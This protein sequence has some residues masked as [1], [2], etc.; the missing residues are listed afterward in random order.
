MVRTGTSVVELSD[1]ARSRIIALNQI[2]ATRSVR[3]NTPKPASRGSVSG[4]PTSICCLRPASGLAQK[5]E[6]VFSRQS[7]NLSTGASRACAPSPSR[8][9]GKTWQAT[10]RRNPLCIPA[11]LLRGGAV[12][13]FYCKELFLTA[14]HGNQVGH[15]LARHCQRGAVGIAFLFLLVVEHGQLRAVARGHFCRFDQRGL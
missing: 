6:F 5:I 15:E 8:F 1:A 9:N 7:R 13:S 2:L 12:F 3:V 14:I 10:R 4:Y 11:A